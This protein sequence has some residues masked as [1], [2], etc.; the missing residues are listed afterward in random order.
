MKDEAFLE[1]IFNSGIKDVLKENNT[2]YESMIDKVLLNELYKKFDVNNYKEFLGKLLPISFNIVSSNREGKFDLIV[3]KD[4]KYLSNITFLDKLTVST[5]VT[6]GEDIDYINLRA[7]PLYKIQK[8]KYRIIYPLFAIE[9]TYNGLYFL[10]KEINEG[11]SDKLKIN[12]RQLITFDFSEKYLL[13]KILGRAF[14]KKYFKLEGQQ[15]STDGAPD[16]YVRNGNKIYLFESK[17]VL[18]N[19]KVKESYEDN[20]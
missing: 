8:D 11:L 6:D 14:N 4:S 1:G 20:N 17:D 10:L 18:V 2:S 16:Y 5:E 13:Y 12:L 3:E 7:N 19:A 15:M 9:K